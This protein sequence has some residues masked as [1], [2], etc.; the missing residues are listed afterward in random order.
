MQKMVKFIVIH[1]LRDSEEKEHILN[2]KS[3]AVY[4]AYSDIFSKNMTQRTQI[5]KNKFNREFVHTNILSGLM[6]ACSIL[7]FF[8]SFRAKNNCWL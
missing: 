1:S 5:L 7:A 2:Q 3:F 6:S 8:K 4:L